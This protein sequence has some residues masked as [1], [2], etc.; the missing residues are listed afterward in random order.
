MTILQAPDT[1]AQPAADHLLPRPRIVECLEAAIDRPLVLLEAPAG[2]GKTCAVL[3]WMRQTDTRRDYT[4]VDL[5]VGDQPRRFVGALAEGLGGTGRDAAGGD[6]LLDLP[7]EAAVDRIVDRLRHHGRE[8]VT[9][10]D[11]LD[12]ADEG[13][14][15]LVRRLVESLPSGAHVV[16]TSRTRPPIGVPRL[17]SWLAIAE[18]GPDD[19]RFDVGEASALLRTSLGLEV[20]RDTIADVTRRLDGWPAGLQL[21]GLAARSA[22][23]PGASLRRAGG[24]HPDIDAYLTSEVLPTIDDALQTF[25]V[26]TAPLE[27]LSVSLCEAATGRPDVARQLRALQSWPWTDLEYTETGSWLRL[28]P[29]LHD[30]LLALAKRTQPQRVDLV[31]DRAARWCAR[32]D[33]LEEALTYATWGHQPRLLAWLLRGHGDE[34]LGRGQHVR[35]LAA[36]ESLPQRLTASDPELYLL[37]AEAA[38]ALQDGDARERFLAMARLP[39]ELPADRRNALARGLAMLEALTLLDAGEVAAA[40]DRLLRLDDTPAHP[41]PGATAHLGWSGPRARRLRAMIEFLARGPVSVDGR[42]DPADSTAVRAFVAYQHGDSEQAR[43]LAVSVPGDVALGTLPSLDRTLELLLWALTR[44]WADDDEGTREARETAAT[45]AGRRHWW[46]ADLTAALTAAEDERRSHRWRG[47][48]R[49]LET[50]RQALAGAA[51]PG[52]VPVL[53]L[54]PQLQR[55][56]I[57]EGSGASQLTERELDIL[58]QLAVQR[59]RREVAE[60]LYVSPNTIK[61]HLRAIYR[62]LGVATREQAITRARELGLLEVSP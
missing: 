37:S 23:D 53:F 51:D 59:S 9:I 52:A 11:G 13:V 45:L 30:W 35:L 29:L 17:R 58:R 20:D 26:D 24:D 22:D 1:A 7:P 61:T 16:L 42:V 39:G 40:R 14:L 6:G 15:H 41:P 56:E 48:R 18:I 62:K 12:A 46:L 19:L 3:E 4:W 2:Y 57:R 44:A 55:L 49:S 25:L 33:L 32:H 60:A 10:L 50:A 5:R 54:D 31:L 21:V 38:L 28:H 43:V 27:R 8:V 47:V 36:V 34:L